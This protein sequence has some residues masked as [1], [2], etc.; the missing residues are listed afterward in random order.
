MLER[1]NLSNIILDILL[2]PNVNTKASFPLQPYR[3][4]CVEVISSTLVLRKQRNTLRF[5]TTRFKMENWLKPL[6]LKIPKAL[7]AR[8]HALSLR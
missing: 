5:A 1:I 2:F 3:S 7:V 6:A 8:Q 4:I